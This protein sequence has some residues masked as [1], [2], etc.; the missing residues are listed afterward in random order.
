MVSYSWY[1][2]QVRPAVALVQSARFTQNRGDSLLSAQP[3]LCPLRC[4]ASRV[5]SL[6]Q[7]HLTNLR[8]SL[9]LRLLQALYVIVNIPVLILA[10]CQTIS[11]RLSPEPIGLKRYFHFAALLCAIVDLVRSV[12]MHSINGFYPPRTDAVLSPL[13]SALV[14]ACFSGAHPPAELRGGLRPVSGGSP[15]VRALRSLALV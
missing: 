5:L 12:D 3:L 4:E 8:C 14:V 13:V 1:A 11:S 6:N 15:I 9:G 2:E 7:Q 10:L